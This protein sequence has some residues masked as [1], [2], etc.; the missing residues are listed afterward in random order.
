MTLKYFILVGIGGSNL[1]A[2]AVYDAL[3]MP[4][5]GRPELLCA[6]TVAPVTRQRII[7]TIKGTPKEQILLNYV[8]KSGMTLES[9]E[10]FEVLRE[11]AGTV[12]DTYKDFEF[13]KNIGGRY[14]V[15]TPVGTYPLQ[16]LGFDAD[17]F[18]KGKEAASTAEAEASAAW[19]FQQL[20]AGMAIHDLFI[21]NPE[22]ES[23]GK[24]YRQLMGES[25]GK[26]GKGFLPT[27]SVGSTDL[28]SMF[29]RYIG[30]PR[31]IATTFV[32]AHQPGDQTIAALYEATKTVY[33]TEGVPFQEYMMPALNEFEIGKFMQFK[34]YEIIHLAKLMGVNA[35]DQPLVELYK[36]EARRLLG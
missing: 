18:L 21:F 5:D 32:R 36:T 23:L 26:E 3:K 35:F 27:V 20:E 2:K 28:H 29:Q 19:L 22:L 8:S 6:D 14:S 1:G 24:W 33:K 12:V 7:E 15:F 10:N 4:N 30:G 25:T 17:A 34:M 13:D 31:N 16:T 11:Y 9:K